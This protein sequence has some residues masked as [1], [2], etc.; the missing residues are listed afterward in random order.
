MVIDDGTRRARRG[1]T[2]LAP[3]GRDEHVTWWRHG[4]VRIG[5]QQPRGRGRRKTRWSTGHTTPSH[6]RRSGYRAGELQ[7]RLTIPSVVCSFAFLLFARETRQSLGAWQP[8]QA[9]LCEDGPARALGSSTA[10]VTS[11]RKFQHPTR[12]ASTRHP[13]PSP[14]AHRLLPSALTAS[15][16]W[17]LPALAR[18]PAGCTWP[19]RP[20]SRGR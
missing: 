17:S 2:S 15:H 18:V 16:P 12:P 11:N 8:A 9:A 3:V 10:D 19:R 4:I 5:I 14:I 1:G 6:P 7:L 13:L 20:P